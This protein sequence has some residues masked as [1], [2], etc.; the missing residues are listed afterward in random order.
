MCASSW[1]GVRPSPTATVPVGRPPRVVPQVITRQKDLEQSHICL[2]TNSY[3]Q[4]HD[5]RYVSYIMN[6]V[7]AGR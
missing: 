5:D 1:N 2:G 7:L 4:N 3:P 6:T